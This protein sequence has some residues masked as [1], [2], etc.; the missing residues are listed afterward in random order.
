MHLQANDTKGSQQPL[1][2]ERGLGQI[3]SESLQ[4]EHGPADP[5]IMDF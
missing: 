3:L 5:L 4:I 2:A 1:E